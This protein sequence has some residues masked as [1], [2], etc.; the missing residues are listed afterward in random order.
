MALFIAIAAALTL[1][2]LGGALWPLWRN[3]RGLAIGLVLLL[4]VAASALYRI[5]GTP[6][7]VLAQPA[8]VMATP[9]SLDDAIAALRTELQRNPDQ[10]EGW[11]LLGRSLVAQGDFPGS[12]EAFDK[13][14][15]LQPGN[16]DLMVD[17]AQARSMT[18]PQ[19]EFDDES[20]ALLRKA[21]Q[22]QP[23]HQRATWFVGIAQR[24]RG[25]AAEAAKTWEPL[26]SQVDADTAT[27]LRTQINA[28]RAEAG[29]PPLAEPAAAPASANALT[30]KV[31][32][33]PDFAS[34]VRLRGD[35]TVFV[36]ARIPGGP[37]MPVAAEKHAL[38]ELPLTVT[39][40]D[41]DSPM[42]TQKLSSLKEVEVFARISASGN[43]MP[44]DGDTTSAPVRINLPADKPVELVLG[45]SP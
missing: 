38:S 18:N 6:A 25:Q 14:L 43:A 8:P 1:I 7:G 35:A 9:Q 11:Q 34:R 15:A 36:I 29:L 19:H 22:A 3:S 32:L 30:V 44:Q 37:P 31:A 16:A 12:R 17:A 4:C 10:P 24:Q 23:Q 39:L 28:A 40:D 13:A 27:N 5:V 45:K 21:L 33:D 41:A 20:L 2:V 26:L 42:P